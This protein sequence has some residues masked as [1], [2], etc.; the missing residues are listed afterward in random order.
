MTT[1]HHTWRWE[2]L[3]WYGWA[4]HQLRV[5]LGYIQQGGQRHQ[6]GDQGGYEERPEERP[7]NHAGELMMVV[8]EEPQSVLILCLL[9]K[10]QMNNCKWLLNTSALITSTFSLMSYHFWDSYCVYCLC[11]FCNYSYSYFLSVTPEFPVWDP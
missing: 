6:G 3:L 7:W 8:L 9:Y 5:D 10:I 1:V 2:W 4:T 11:I